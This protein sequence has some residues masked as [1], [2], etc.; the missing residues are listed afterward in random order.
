[1]A[2][3]DLVIVSGYALPEPSEYSANTATLVDSARNAEGY[4]IG[5]V[6]RDDVAKIEISWRYLTVTQWSDILKCFRIASDGKFVNTVDFFAQDVAGWVTKEMYISDRSSGMWR[7]NHETG[8]VMGW[9]GCK[10]SL[11]EV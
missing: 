2:I 6:L 3:R 5:S 4:M 7:R 1:M 9:V 10:L 8:D 11:V